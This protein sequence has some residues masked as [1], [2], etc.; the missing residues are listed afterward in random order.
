V[1]IIGVLEYVDEEIPS[2]LNTDE[3]HKSLPDVEGMT[4]QKVIKELGL[5]P[6]PENS[7]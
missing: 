3:W 4:P 1:E 7:R 5:K 2:I 6:K